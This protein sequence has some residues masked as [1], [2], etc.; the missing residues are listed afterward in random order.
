[1]G[2]VVDAILRYAHPA[3]TRVVAA[4]T[5]WG[6][7][8]RLLGMDAHNAGWYRVVIH[9]SSRRWARHVRASDGSGWVKAEVNVFV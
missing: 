1:M 8:R 3:H 2:G 4:V 6:V 9:P 7:L 5:H